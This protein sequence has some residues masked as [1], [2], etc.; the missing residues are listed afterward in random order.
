M[1]RTS[2][3]LPSL[4]ASSPLA[5]LTLSPVRRGRRRGPLLQGCLRTRAEGGGVRFCRV[6]FGRRCRRFV[7]PR[8]EEG[9]ITPLRRGDEGGLGWWSCQYDFF[10]VL[11]VVRGRRR[12]R[13]ERVR[14][15]SLRRSRFLRSRLGRKSTLSGSLLLAASLHLQ[16]HSNLKNT[17]ESGERGEAV[18]PSG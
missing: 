15:G 12:E 1:P 16:L 14:E 10:L 4:P 8:K 17:S 18:G 11:S 13:L 3:S 7:V 5:S 6:G 2:P 9:V